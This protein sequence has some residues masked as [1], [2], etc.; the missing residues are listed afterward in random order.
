MLEEG[1]GFGRAHL[2]S[3]TFVP[4]H[5]QNGSY[6][7]CIKSFFKESSSGEWGGGRTPF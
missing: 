4:A 5:R 3:F 2:F 1:D 6:R 7:T